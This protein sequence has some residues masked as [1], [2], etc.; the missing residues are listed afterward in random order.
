MTRNIRLHPEYG[1]NPSMIVCPYCGEPKAIAL[2]GN[3]CKKEAPHTIWDGDYTPCDDCQNKLKEKN[4]MYLLNTNPTDLTPT[5]EYIL[6]NKSIVEKIFDKDN[7]KEDIYI[8]RIP[9]EIFT[10]IKEK[11]KEG[12]N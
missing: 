10:E 3:S 1:F 9:S 2:L 12:S 11:I 4:Q 6:M 5:G 7:I 8:A